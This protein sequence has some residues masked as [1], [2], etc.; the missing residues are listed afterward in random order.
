MRHS[1]TLFGC[2]AVP[3]CGLGQ[4]LG[5]ALTLVIGKAQVQ[6]TVRM[7][8]L[9]GLA[10]PIDGLDEVLLNRFSSLVENPEIQLRLKITA[11]GCG[12]DRLNIDRFFR[13]NHRPEDRNRGQSHPKTEG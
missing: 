2:F 5:N 13:R 3:A 11:L 10:I 9:C 7:S 6:L 8:S 1:L 4:V 12:L